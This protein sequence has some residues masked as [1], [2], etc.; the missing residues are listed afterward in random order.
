MSE[1]TKEEE[2]QLCGEFKTEYEVEPCSI[3]KR[4]ACNSCTYGPDNQFCEDCWEVIKK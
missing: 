4:K 2:C 3:C 1:E